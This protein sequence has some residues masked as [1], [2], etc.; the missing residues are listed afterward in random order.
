MPRS[1]LALLGTARQDFVLAAAAALREGGATVTGVVAEGRE[2]S[3]REAGIPATS[4][5][6]RISVWSLR[7]L[8]TVRRLRPTGV[9]VV[10]GDQVAHTN[11][12]TALNWWRATG[13]LRG[14]DIYL[15][16]STQPAVL[17]CFNSSDQRERLFAALAAGTGAIALLFWPSAVLTA[18]AAAACFE[19]AARLARRR[20]ATPFASSP[21]PVWP[22][23]ADDPELGWRPRPVDITAIT[24]TPDTAA[25]TRRVNIDSAGHRATGSP[26]SQSDSGPLVAMYGGAY[27]FGDALGDEETIPARV[28]VHLTRCRIVNRGVPGYGV[29]QSASRLL[30]DLV[31]APP[32]AVVLVLS[33]WEFA[34]RNVDASAGRWRFRGE[35]SRF[36]LSD[37]LATIWFV[38]RWQNNRWA[39]TNRRVALQGLSDGCSRAGIPAILAIAG[40]EFATVEQER[41]WPG[42]RLVAIAEGA[43]EE[44]V[45]SLLAAEIES[46]IGP[47]E[48]P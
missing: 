23:L 28:A 14:A 7:L 33:A 6:G 19:F 39:Q 9:V 15:S 3:L 32:A 20:V 13:L 37:R 10:A 21:A 44:H 42:I 24:T 8:M 43:S 27:L 38:K 2:S 34:R 16:L 22:L 4:F 18:L 26:A 31:D 1:N 25:L 5:T 45:A 48:R 46:A 47:G 35:H 17:E 36:P 11:V 30:M 29:A 12:L 41:D 40:P